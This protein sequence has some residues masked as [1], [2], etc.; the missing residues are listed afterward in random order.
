MA[1]DKSKFI[2]VQDLLNLE[3]AEYYVTQHFDIN[4]KRIKIL[5]DIVIDICEK[6]PSLKSKFAKELVEL[7]DLDKRQ[8]DLETSLFG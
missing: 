8:S 7:Q 1:L 5:S 6:V 4:T 2:C 3:T